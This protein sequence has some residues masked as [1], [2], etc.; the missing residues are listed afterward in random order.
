MMSLLIT[1]RT[2]HLFAPVL[3][4]GQPGLDDWLPVVALA[5]GLVVFAGL[6]VYNL[7]KQRSAPSDTPARE[8]NR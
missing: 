1:F 8:R 6:A 5:L 4:G 3:H 7:K 2:S